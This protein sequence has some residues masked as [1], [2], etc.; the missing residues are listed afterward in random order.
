VI[1]INRDGNAR[2]QCCG[3]KAAGIA[4]RGVRFATVGPSAADLKFLH[5]LPGIHFRNF[6]SKAALES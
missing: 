1:E 2:Q 5:H 3:A 6:K 4:S